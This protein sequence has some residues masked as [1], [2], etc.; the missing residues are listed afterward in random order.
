M[1]GK[2]RERSKMAKGREGKDTERGGMGKKEGKGWKQKE[3]GREGKPEKLPK[4]TIKKKQIFKFM[5]SCT[6]PLPDRPNLACKRGPMVY[7][8]V[9]NFIVIGVMY[10][11]PHNHANMTDFGNFGGSCTDTYRPI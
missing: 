2:G 3:R 7:S 8:S 5:V 6:H 11:T 1:E 10:I 9:P 4:T